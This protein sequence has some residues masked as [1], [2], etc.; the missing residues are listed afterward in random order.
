[1]SD[2]SNDTNQPEG[3][4]AENLDGSP[5][6]GSP[7]PSGSPERKP[8]IFAFINGGGGDMLFPS[9]ISEDGFGLA[10]HCSS[11]I[12][13]AKH[14]MG[15]GSDWQHEKYN[16]H[17]PNGWELEWVDKPLDHAGVMKAVALLNARH[18]SDSVAKPAASAEQSPSEVSQ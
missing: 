3:A 15:I 9:A 1:M 2:K 11:S 12:G 8:K 6:A 13:W 4:Q 7:S 17:Y 10:G 5:E 14:D 16:K 18:A